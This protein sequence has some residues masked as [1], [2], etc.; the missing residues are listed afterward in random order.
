MKLVIE[1]SWVSL[2]LT[3]CR[4]RVRSVEG[5]SEFDGQHC[6][7]ENGLYDQH[8]DEKWNHRCHLKPEIR[9]WLSH[10]PYMSWKSEFPSYKGDLGMSLW[11]R[12]K[13][14]VVMFK[15][16]WGGL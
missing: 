7:R 9:S 5:F 1:D 4:Y 8:L 10:L 12:R 16:A 2:L 13:R 3:G 15:L 6:W 14:D 11:F